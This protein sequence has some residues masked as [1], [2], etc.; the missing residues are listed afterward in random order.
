MGYFVRSIKTGSGATAVQVVSKFRGKRRIEAHI[1][2]AHSPEGVEALK[3]AAR[4]RVDQLERETGQQEFDFGSSGGVS[5]GGGVRLSGA[6]SRVLYETLVGVYDGLGFHAAL[7]DRVF[8]DLVVARV[9]RPASKRETITILD[10]LGVGSPS[11]SSIHRAL[12]RSV[13]RDYR[14]KISTACVGVRGVQ[15]L[16]LVLY[17]VTTLFFQVER[18]DEYRKP[19][20]S[21]ERRLEPQIVVGLLADAQG[22]PLQVHSFEGNTAETLTLVPVLDA[23]SRTHP[24]VTVTVVCDAGMLSAKNMVALEEAGYDFVVGSKIAKTPYDIAEYQSDGTHLSDGQIFDTTASFG[25]GTARRKRRVV[26]QYREKRARLDLKNIDTQ[27]TKAQ[28]V[29]NGTTPVK[30]NRFLTLTNHKHTLNTRLIDIARA[31]AGIKGYVTSLT[32]TQAPPEQIIS[33]YHQLYHVEAAFR[34]AKTDLKARPIYHRIREK[35]EAHLT[36]VFAAMAISTTIQ[37]RTGLSIKRVV[38]LL[39]PIRDGTLT[40]NGKQHHIPADIPDN[41]HHLINQLTQ[42]TGH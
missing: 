10:R 11:Y 17:D 30:K 13:E 1:G 31:R 16:T 23:F 24:G 29:I 26:Y 36:I 21:K 3:Q 27:I 2:S 15:R 25:H 33:W 5:A 39:E 22:F 4:E 41:I 9:I 38:T 19:G 28:R 12:N 34:M 14:E 18:E 42:K 7:Q 35:I 6:Y 37:E 32:P 20:L 40:I 8:R